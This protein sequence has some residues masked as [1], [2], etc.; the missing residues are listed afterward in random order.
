MN[1]VGGVHV[2]CPTPGMGAKGQIFIFLEYG[3][4]AYQI[5]GIY[6][7]SNTVASIMRFHC[8]LT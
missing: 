1:T 8:P 6:A 2:E 3:H 7:Y 5:E 4:A